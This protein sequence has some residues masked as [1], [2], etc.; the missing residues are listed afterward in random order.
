LIQTQRQ[1][2]VRQFAY[3]AI[4]SV[5]FI[6]YFDKVANVSGDY[7]N[8]AMSKAMKKRCTLS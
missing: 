3:E 1:T 4:K 2:D 5:I 8:P 6:N 7:I